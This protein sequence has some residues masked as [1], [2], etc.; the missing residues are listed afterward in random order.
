M[1]SKTKATTGFSLSN[2]IGYFVLGFSTPRVIVEMMCGGDD[3][4]LW[5]MI[6]VCGLALATSPHTSLVE[7]GNG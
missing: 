3:L 7:V 1:R 5:A 6:L 4:T 2:G